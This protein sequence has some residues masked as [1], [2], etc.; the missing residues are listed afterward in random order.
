[1][2]VMGP[3]VREAVSLGVDSI[4]HGTWADEVTVREMAAT[5]G[6]RAYFG[7]PGLEPGAPADLVTFDR[8]PR[9]DITALA[10]PAAIVAGGQRVP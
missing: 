10:E 8:D 1:M 6:A 4:E 2:H 9:A 7:L 3:F 5:T